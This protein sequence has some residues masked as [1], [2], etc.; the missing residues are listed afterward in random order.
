VNDSTI[1][2]NDSNGINCNTTGGI[3]R[4]ATTGIYN[5]ANGIVIAPG[6]TVESAG[7]NPVAGNGPSAAPNG[8]VPKQ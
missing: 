1:S 5:N 6:C 7:D 4:L 2:F 8:I 3:I